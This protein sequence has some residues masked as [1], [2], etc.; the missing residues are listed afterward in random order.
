[1]FGESFQPSK[2][3]KAMIYFEG[4]DLHL[5]KPE[6]KETLAKAVSNIRKLPQIKLAASTL[7]LTEVNLR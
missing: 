7:E 2:S 3:L 5:L 4:V 1:M 6:T